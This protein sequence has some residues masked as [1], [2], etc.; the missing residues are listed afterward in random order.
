[1]LLQGFSSN[2]VEYVSLKLV[3]CCLPLE[4]P[5]NAFLFSPEQENLNFLPFRWVEF[6]DQGTPEKTRKFL[7]MNIDVIG[8]ESS[9]HLLGIVKDINSSTQDKNPSLVNFAG[10]RSIR[11]F[12]LESMKDCILEIN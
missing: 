4:Y 9:S 12:P 5:L 3:F 1:M 2:S 10:D 6:G 8:V 11:K 7:L